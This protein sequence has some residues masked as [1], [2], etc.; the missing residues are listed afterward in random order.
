LFCYFASNQMKTKTSMKKQLTTL[1]FAFYCVCAAQVQSYGQDHTPAIQTFLTQLHQEKDHYGLTE[2]D[3]QHHEVTDVYLSKRSGATHVY[4]RQVYEGVSVLQ[5][6][7]NASVT[8]EGRLL[9]TN[10][11]F[12]P[13][14]V[15]RIGEAGPSLSATDA[16][17]A[18]SQQLNLPV[19][20]TPII[21]SNSQEPDRE[22]TFLEAG[23]ALEPMKAKLVYQRSEDGKVRLSWQVRI[24]ELSAQHHW[25]VCIDATTGEILAKEDFVKHSSFGDPREAATNDNIGYDP[26]YASAHQIQ[27]NTLNLMPNS[28]LVYP[29]PVESP[30]HG[31]MEL[32]TDPANVIASP[33]GWHDT[34]GMPGA[35]YT[36]TR[37]NN[38]HAYQDSQGYN[39]SLGD[40]PDGGADL[41]FN[42]PYLPGAEPENYRKTAVT[43][44]FYWTNLMHDVWYQ[45]GFD[46]AAGNYQEN[47]YGNGGIGND[48]MIAEA[49]DVGGLNNTN[50]N[51][52][53]D[54]LNGRIQVYLYD[55]T[56]DNLIINEPPE[57]EGNYDVV[58]AL[59]G[60]G[61]PTGNPI[62]SDINLVNDGTANPSQA[63]QPLVN[64]DEI[65]NKMALI[66]QGGCPF[67]IKVKNAQ[68]AGAAVAIVCRSISN[69]P[70]FPMWGDD[71]DIVIPAV[72]ISKSDCDQI[73]Q[74]ITNGVAVNASLD[75]GPDL[76][77]SEF[78]D[79]DFDSGAL[80]H[81]YA[82]GISHR[83]TGGPSTTS[84]LSNAEQMGPGWGDWMA[85]MMTIEEGDEGEDIRGVG[86]FVLNQPVNGSG[87]RPA[88]YSTDFDINSYTYGNS[89]DVSNIVQP[90][91]IGFIWATMLWDLTWA[92]VEEYGLDMDFY[93][94]TGGNNMAMALVT[95]AMKIQPCS[96]GMVD[97]RDAILLA[98]EIL[99]GGDH[100]CLIWEVF[101]KRGL[102]YSASQGSSDS[103]TDQ[104]ESFDTILTC[105]PDGQAPTAAFEVIPFNDCLGVFE[106]SDN[107]FNTPQTWKWDLGDGTIITGTTEEVKTV[108]H[109]YAEEGTYSVTLKVTNL[110]GGDI[111]GT[112]VVVEYPAPPMLDP[113]DPVCEGQAT[114]LSGT[115][116]EGTI[117]WFQDGEWVGQGTTFET[118]E[119]NGTTVFDA[120]T[121][122][123]A[124]TSATG[125][126]V[127]NTIGTGG[128]HG[129]IFNARIIFESFK[130]FVLRTAWVDAEYAGERIIKLFD[131]NE[132][133]VDSVIVFME[134]GP[135]TVNLNIEVPVPGLYSIGN[136]ELDLFRNDSGAE[137]PYEVGDIAVLTGS[138]A[139]TDPQAY[140]YYLYNW[141]V[142]DLTCT[143]ELVSVEVMTIPSPEAGFDANVDG[144]EVTFTE[145]ADGE[146]TYL[147]E[148]G[149]GETSTDPNPTHLYTADGTYTV[150]LTVS[151]GDCE[152]VS[153]LDV[154][155]V[156]VGT[157]DIPQLQDFTLSPNPGT[158]QFTLNINLNQ[159]SDVR[160]QVIDVLGRVVWTQERSRENIII[161][162]I[163]LAQSAAGTYFVSIEV[164]GNTAFR[165]YV[166]MK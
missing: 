111:V 10:V 141:Y 122:L 43:N 99:Y 35:E 51:T 97:G 160:I 12:I 70:P 102:G 138:N 158:G 137:Y 133:F 126:P 11:S 65:Q 96:P 36:I 132:E 62:T 140:Y 54:G 110:L 90:H 56:P 42:F 8:E 155:I 26:H 75:G 85:L 34:D 117:N 145:T 49:Q 89:N 28:Y 71:D 27:K 67:T 14:L 1:L 116:D 129:T 73:K 103:R 123:P 98:D 128:Y 69:S 143:S 21:I 144:A 139:T 114:V 45:Y 88:P 68:D 22:T 150:T 156:S 47:N 57:I 113:V 118:P 157:N 66:D 166:L 162:D 109:Q 5:G 101:A 25:N 15:S 13:N 19:P 58:E 163:D 161:E 48:L 24:Y 100:Q 9:S 153:T 33:F 92:L 38:V 4:L 79:T 61:L 31:D 46:E 125:G 30:N 84:C 17:I 40:E 37:G 74:Q 81:S 120:Q 105:D 78:L 64:P 3:I 77:G 148:F 93:H 32:V 39:E 76:P 87:L 134:E 121:T 41:T 55:I 86:T 104:V 95:E 124:S 2:S 59:F 72:M 63:C 147:W 7:A 165:K 20:G 6:F 82:Y 18:V 16:L 164:D 131:E 127:N 112:T 136:S 50:F 94:G 108:I 53:Q 29:M 159:A 154:Q 52:G 83:L 106:F 119:I 151:N 44:L 152:D 80:C 107:S 23:W 146:T 135:Q 91:G 142:E 149:D 115:T 60:P 130:P